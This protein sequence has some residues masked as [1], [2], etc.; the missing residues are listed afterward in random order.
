LKNSSSWEL[1]LSN[2]IL[3]GFKSCGKTTLGKK[4]A[5]RLGR[6]FID[7]DQLVSSNCQ[8]V[9][10][11]EGPEVFRAMEKQ[12]I[13]ALTEFHNC[14][15]AT[16][17]GSML[18]PDNVVIFKKLGRI[19]YL[20]IEK[21]ELKRRIFSDELPAYFNPLEP[22][23]SFEQMVQSRLGIF[24]AIADDVISNEE[25]AWAAIHS[26]RFSESRRGASPMEKPLES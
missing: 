5:D 24:E 18:D 9:Y 1:K 16:G 7:T 4:L 23:E 12:V 20:R 17:G 25:E 2:I 15:I 10:L 11:E 21:D 8:A 19:L 14:V 3:C 26:E 13:A 6:H 22:E